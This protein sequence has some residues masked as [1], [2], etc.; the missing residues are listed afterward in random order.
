MDHSQFEPDVT[1]MG[2][3]E[4]KKK[5]EP[6]TENQTK[7]HNPDSNPPQNDRSQMPHHISTVWSGPREGSKAKKTVQVQ[8]GVR[9]IKAT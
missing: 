4:K 3:T 1:D 2:K 5:Q 9:S 6:Q 7:V 8:S